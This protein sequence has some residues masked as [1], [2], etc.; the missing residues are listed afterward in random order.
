MFVI[1]IIGEFRIIPA[2]M[3]THQDF[4]HLAMPESN[5]ICSAENGSVE[6]IIFS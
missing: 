5:I 1:G 2:G 4:H 3:K 6:T